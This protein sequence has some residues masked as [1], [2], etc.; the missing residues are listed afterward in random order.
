M[1]SDRIAIVTGGTRG[2]GRDIVRHLIEEGFFV[3]FTYLSSGENSKL[4]E[5]QFRGQCK[6]T[7]VDGCVEQNVRGY[8]AEIA[9][10]NQK[11]AVM[12]N[13]AGITVDYLIKDAE[14]VKYQKIFEVNVGGVFN[15][16]RA[17]LPIMMKQRYGDII[18]ISSLATHNIRMGN[19]FLWISL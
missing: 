13:N 8:I 5:D 3:H 12:V 15:F 9:N 16:S 1:N 18:N 10:D 7:S 2:I 4:L 14:W 19:S 6:G 17:V 11:I